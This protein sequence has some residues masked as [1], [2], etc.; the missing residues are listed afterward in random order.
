M[1]AQPEKPVRAW[2]VELVDAWVDGEPTAPIVG[3]IPPHLVELAKAMARASCERL[4][5]LARR[6]E[7]EGLAIVPMPRGADDPMVLR[8]QVERLMARLKRERSEG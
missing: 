2:A 3:M 5:F 1:R 8:R 6:A 7:R 4:R